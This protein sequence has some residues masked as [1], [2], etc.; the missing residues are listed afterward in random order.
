RSGPGRSWRRSHALSVDPSPNDRWLP[1]RNSHA[2]PW[3]LRVFSLVSHP[4]QV[5]DRGMWSGVP[6]GQPSTSIPGGDATG[7]VGAVELAALRAAVE[8]LSVPVDGDVLVE[9][10]GLVDRLQARA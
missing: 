3:R 9:L 7:G 10:L 2:E 5:Y 1:G 8:G 6:S 4:E